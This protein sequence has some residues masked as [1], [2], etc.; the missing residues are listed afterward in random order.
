M[1]MEKKKEKEKEKE[2]ENEG[3]YGVLRFKFVSAITA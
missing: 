1:D 2:T 3:L